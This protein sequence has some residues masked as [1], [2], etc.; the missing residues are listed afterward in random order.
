[1]T[2]GLSTGFTKTLTL[3]GVGYRAFADNK[4]LTLNLG[5]SNP[6]VMQ[7]PEGVEAQVRAL[8]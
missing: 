8:P 6:V 3:I 1:M 7:L 5:F 4:Q 2:E